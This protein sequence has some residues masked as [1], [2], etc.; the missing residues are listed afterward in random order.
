MH[1]V[2]GVVSIMID[3][4]G[5]MTDEWESMAIDDLIALHEQ[6]VNV[7]KAKLFAKMTE[8]ER[9]LL[10]LGQ[11]PKLTETVKPGLPGLLMAVGQCGCA[12]KLLPLAQAL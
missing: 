4:E 5:V 6:M 10:I 1:W 11:Q 9:R 12:W 8:L 7:L 3:R 2:D